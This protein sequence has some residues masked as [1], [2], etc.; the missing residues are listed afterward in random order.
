MILFFRASLRSLWSPVVVLIGLTFGLLGVGILAD[1]RIGS[2]I[3]IA[4]IV[5]GIGVTGVG[6]AFAWGGSRMGV[7]RTPSGLAVREVFGGETYEPSLL[8]GF[9]VEEE[10]HDM[11]PLKVV[12]PVI[13]LAEGDD[14]QVLSL[15]TYGIFPGARKRA[16]RAADTMAAWTGKPVLE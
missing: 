12:F 10:D 9:S 8:A 4:S 16:A 15:A 11:L 3:D 7:V 14:V 5:I 13:R 2:R 6:L 1:P